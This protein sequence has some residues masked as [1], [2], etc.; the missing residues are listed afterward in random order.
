[1]SSQNSIGMSAHQSQNN[2]P[3]SPKIS[4]NEE[5]FQKRVRE[6]NEQPL[7]FI[8]INLGDETSER[9]VVYDGDS[10]KELSVK[11][12]EEHSKQCIV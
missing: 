10:A 3:D 1:M 9:I 4:D 2:E 6:P 8:D 7:L 12:C 5:S 11:F